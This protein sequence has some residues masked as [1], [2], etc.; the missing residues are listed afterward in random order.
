MLMAAWAGICFLIPTIMRTKLSWYL[1]PFYPP[2]ALGVA[3]L[4]VQ[5]ASASRQLIFRAF[6]GGAD[7]GEA[8]KNPTGFAAVDTSR[9]DA[10]KYEVR[11][12]KYDD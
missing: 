10:W 2:F 7:R 11:S 3:W 8:W 6:P 9:A 12:L 4:F 1:N 5:G